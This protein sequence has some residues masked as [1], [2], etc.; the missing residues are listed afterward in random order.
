M[1]MLKLKRLDRPSSSRSPY[2]LNDGQD[3]ITEVSRFLDVLILRGLSLNTVRTY[4]FDLLALYRF[5]DKIRVSV[6][7]LKSHHAMEFLAVL[8]KRCMAPGTINQRIKTAVSF[9][10][11]LKPHWGDTLFMGRQRRF[12]KGIKNRALLGPSR[13]KHSSIPQT[14]RVKVPKRLCLPL[15]KQTVR[16]L[17]SHLTTYRDRSIALLMLCSGLR[18][19][20]VLVLSIHDVDFEGR[21]I[22]VCGKGNKQRRLPLSGWVATILKLY[23]R[24]ERPRVSHDVCFV[25]L[26]GKRRGQPLAM[27]GLRKIFRY[28]RGKSSLLKEANPHRLRHTF[29]TNLIRHG[30]SLPVVQKLMGHESIETTLI[31]INLSDDDVAKDYHSA[32]SAIERDH[33][34]PKD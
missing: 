32:M 33:E 26:K 27:E 13:L 16:S 7:H 3:V 4:A 22:C 23:L 14:I 2:L 9:L 28:R 1:I 11:F 12:Y 15:S 18:S 31:Y 25:A 21:W 34:K 24:C 5:L 8:R 30:V 17:L 10:N 6:S 29:C 19:C 20:E